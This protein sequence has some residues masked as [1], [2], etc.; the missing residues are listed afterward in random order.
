VLA[1]PGDV[2]KLR[3]ESS[4][5]AKT[6]CSQG[7]GHQRQ[8]NTLVHVFEGQVGGLRPD[9]LGQI[10]VGAE[11]LRWPRRALDADVDDLGA[12]PPPQRDDPTLEPQPQASGRV[13]PRLVVR[14]LNL[15]RTV[16]FASLD[17]LPP[18]RWVVRAQFAL[19][20]SSILSLSLLNPFQNLGEALGE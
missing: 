20:H 15:N 6:P 16:I 13:F 2:C 5:E 19:Y 10:Q 7:V 4:S 3:K 18:G 14:P 8:T 17:M 9:L 12:G 11:I 1:R